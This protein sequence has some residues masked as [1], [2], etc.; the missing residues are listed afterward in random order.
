[1]PKCASKRV[2]IIGEKYP[3]TA[4][5]C[6]SVKG[7]HE[8]I[9]LLQNITVFAENFAN[10]EGILWFK[11]DFNR[12]SKY[13]LTRAPKTLK[14]LIREK[15]GSFLVV[16]NGRNTVQDAI[17]SLSAALNRPRMQGLREWVAEWYPDHVWTEPSWMSEESLKKLMDDVFYGQIDFNWRVQSVL[18][19]NL[20]LEGYN[21]FIKKYN[22]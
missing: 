15:G 3:V 21:E 19:T 11:R 1:M 7:S 4:E 16:D 17:N 6:R 18:R 13:I 9:N 10:V 14:K 5:I 22:K 12:Y 20:G 8:S 2:D